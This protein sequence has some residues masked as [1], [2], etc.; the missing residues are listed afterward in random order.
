M[1]P[2]HGAPA[3]AAQLLL[4]PM[5]APVLDTESYRV[6]GAGF[7]NPRTPLQWYWDQYAPSP[8]DREHP[9]TSP[10]H[11]D[12]R[13]LQPSVVVIGRPRSIT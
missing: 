3:L 4:Y 12:L 2:D 7:Y 8:A 10:L 5:I 6:F 1:A 9:Y 13:G 11:G